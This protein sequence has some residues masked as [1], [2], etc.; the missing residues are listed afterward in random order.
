V[1]ASPLRVAAIVHAESFNIIQCDGYDIH[2]LINA[3]LGFAFLV[4]VEHFTLHLC[5]PSTKDLQ[6]WLTACP[7]WNIFSTTDYMVKKQCQ[8]SCSLQLISCLLHF[9]FPSNPST[10]VS[11]D[12]CWFLNICFTFLPFIWEVTV[13]DYVMRSYVV[14]R[15]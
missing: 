14:V 2:F 9:V 1:L 15:F 3:F 10:V 6:Q 12:G 5:T 13:P 7:F 11:Q 8:T 4:Q